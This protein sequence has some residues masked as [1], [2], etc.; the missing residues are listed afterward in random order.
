MENK[1]EE[2]ITSLKENFFC[3]FK[4]CLR[5]ERKGERGR[6]GLGLSVVLVH[7]VSKQNQ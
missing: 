3:F 6:K 4:L 1:V 2:E 7:F 5:K